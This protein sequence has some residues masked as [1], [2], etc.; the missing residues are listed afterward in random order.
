MNKDFLKKA[1]T[2]LQGRSTAFAVFFAVSGL[3]LE[4][5]GKLSLNYVALIGAVQGLVVVHS[6]KEDKM[7]QPGG[8]DAGSTS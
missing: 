7:K 1:F 6:Y 2:F 3:V 8:D 4:C 5:F